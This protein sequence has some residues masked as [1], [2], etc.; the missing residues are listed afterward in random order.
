[1][2]ASQQEQI[3]AMIFA[4]RKIE[5]IKQYR[6]LNGTDLKDAKQAI[7]TRE[8]ELRQQSPQSFTAGK[9]GCASMIVLALLTAASL[10]YVTTC[11]MG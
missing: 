6:E 3:D 7:D 4:G 10:A 5:A 2:D 11:C 8:R 1:M 9:S